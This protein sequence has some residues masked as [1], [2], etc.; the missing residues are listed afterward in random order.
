MFETY[1]ASSS[2]IAMYDLTQSHHLQQLQMPRHAIDHTLRSQYSQNRPAT[3]GNLRA[4]CILNDASAE[5]Q[6]ERLRLEK[7]YIL[8]RLHLQSNLCLATALP[9]TEDGGI[10]R[11]GKIIFVASESGMAALRGDFAYSS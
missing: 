11:I 5:S 4:A 6:T 1:P 3:T 2:M 10:G 7:Q 9:T 8:F